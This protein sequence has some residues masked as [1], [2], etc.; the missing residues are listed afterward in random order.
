[1]S[2]RLFEITAFVMAQFIVSFR[3]C[4]YEICAKS[5]QQI[6]HATAPE[7]DFLHL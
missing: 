3:E 2:V 1:M 6:I 5:S 7:Q 4:K